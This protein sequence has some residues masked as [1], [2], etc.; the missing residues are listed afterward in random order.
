MPCNM[1]S[2]LNDI[3]ERKVRW[4]KASVFLTV[5]VT[6]ILAVGLVCCRDDA[7]K[8][9]TLAVIV[10]AIFMSMWYF[11]PVTIGVSGQAVVVKKRIGRKTIPFSAIESVSPFTPMP[12]LRNQR[13]CGC[14][15]FAGY[16]GWFTD[17]EIGAYFAYH[18]RSADCFLLRLKDGRLYVLG[19][20]DSP[21]VISFISDH[22]AH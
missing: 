16:W 10:A 6:V 3:M 17:Q 5:I 14:G 21:A 12:W 18:G 11:S 15:G 7:A 9:Y 1:S 13:L 4:G 20:E 19:C 2:G 22:I 8:F